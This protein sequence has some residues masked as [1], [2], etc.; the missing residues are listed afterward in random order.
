MTWRFWGLARCCMFC[1]GPLDRWHGHLAC[2]LVV[3]MDA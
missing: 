1:G 2:F 3:G